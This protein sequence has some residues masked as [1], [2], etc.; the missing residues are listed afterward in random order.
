[1][2]EVKWI[3]ITTSMF[4]DEKI[5]IIESM[6]DADSILV[7]WI[8]LLTLSGKVNS[9]GFIFL[10][11]NIPYTDEMLSNLFSRPLSTVRLALQ[12]FKQFG[13]VEF[14]DKNFLYITNW[15]KHQNIEG[16]EKIREQTRQRV[17]K[18]RENQK[19]LNAGV[20]LPVTH[21]NAIELDKNKNKNK[22]ILSLEI[23]QFRLRYS[24]EQLEIIDRYFEILRTTRVSGKL[25]D[26]I[27]HGVYKEMNKHSPIIVQASCKTVVDQPSLHDK[28]ENYFFGIMRNT[29][30]DEAVRKLSGTQT[31]NAN[32]GRETPD[33]KLA[34]IRAE[35]EAEERE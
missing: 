15:D 35:L 27:I 31:V 8:K 33:Q 2:S 17:A 12:T 18:H 21:G 5:R 14:D 19:E 3:K 22:S 23:D 11:E 6:P 7:I 24:P 30:A 16:L 25:A 1:M 9:N 26:S 13:M 34:R 4:D 20:T 32:K 28:K 10:T 29:K